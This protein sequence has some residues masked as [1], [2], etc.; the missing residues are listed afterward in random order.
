MVQSKE[1]IEKRRQVAQL[2]ELEQSE[3]QLQQLKQDRKGL[4]EEQKQ[5]RTSLLTQQEHIERLERELL[6]V[7]PEQY[8][9]KEQEISKLKGKCA[10]LREVYTAGKEQQAWLDGE[11]QTLQT[12]IRE[13]PKVA[14]LDISREG[15]CVNCV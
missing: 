14:S 6:E 8:E 4:E 1:R 9:S 11:I 3:L 13:M 5:H 7:A 10:Q 15:L 2:A 12:L